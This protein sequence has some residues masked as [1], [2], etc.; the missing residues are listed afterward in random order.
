MLDRS[1]GQEGSVVAAAPF[2]LFVYVG[3]ASEI[4]VQLQMCRNV[5]GIDAAAGLHLFFF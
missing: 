5:P 2:C 1:Q 3:E 4:L